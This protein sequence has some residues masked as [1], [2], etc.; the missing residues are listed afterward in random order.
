MHILSRAGASTYDVRLKYMSVRT[1]FK[2]SKTF[3]NY[4]L[5][6]SNPIQSITTIIKTEL[7]KRSKIVIIVPSMLCDFKVVVNH[8]LEKESVY[9]I[10]PFRT[11]RMSTVKDQTFGFVSD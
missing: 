8:C 4:Q 1:T 10:Y 6:G 11:H 7:E 3:K 9:T 5:T 2:K